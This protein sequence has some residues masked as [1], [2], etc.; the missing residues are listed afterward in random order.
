MGSVHVWKSELYDNK[1]GCVSEF[2]KGVVELL[3]PNNGERILDLGCGTGDLAYEIEKTGA[4]VTGMDL[5]NAM[6]REGA[7]EISGYSFYRRQC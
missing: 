1:L 4:A 2:G 7:N 3:N 5:S 6:Y